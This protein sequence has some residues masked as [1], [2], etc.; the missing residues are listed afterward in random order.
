MRVRLSDIN[1]THFPDRRD[2]DLPNPRF[3]CP[4]RVPYP[5][6]DTYFCGKDEG[7][8]G[9]HWFGFKAWL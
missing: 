8:T 9:P 3:C 7:H 5:A 1:Y 2:L 4:V 6:L